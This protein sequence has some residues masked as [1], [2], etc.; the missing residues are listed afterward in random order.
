M[1][2]GDFADDAINAGFAELVGIEGD[3]YDDVDPMDGIVIRRKRCK[4][5][6]VGGLKWFQKPDGS[7]RLSSGKDAEGNVILHVCEAYREAKTEDDE[8]WDG[9]V[10]F[11]RVPF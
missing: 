11:E 3:Q 9:S 5:C 8:D 10:N 1:S 4:Y 7:W 2:A 6:G